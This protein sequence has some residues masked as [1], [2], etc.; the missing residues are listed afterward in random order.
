MGRSATLCGGKHNTL[1]SMNWDSVKS[2]RTALNE[3]LN[4]YLAGD[5]C[6]TGAPI[7]ARK[8]GTYLDALSEGFVSAIKE[9]L[10]N[11]DGQIVGVGTAISY[12]KIYTEMWRQATLIQTKLNGAIDSDVKWVDV[13]P[14]AQ[15]AMIDIK[16]LQALNDKWRGW[17]GSPAQN[18]LVIV[19][20]CNLA[21]A[22]LKVMEEY[23]ST[24]PI[25]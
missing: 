3:Q 4:I 19:L 25:P 15:L 16:T 1:L 24:E 7:I 17:K 5:A 20:A 11:L 9:E 6:V 10:S 14:A 21:D 18:D 2:H 22:Y 12:A 23:V 8:E 13:E